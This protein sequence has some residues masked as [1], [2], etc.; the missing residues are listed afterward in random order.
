MPQCCFAP[1]SLHRLISSCPSLLQFCGLQKGEKDLPAQAW[2]RMACLGPL[3][4]VDRVPPTVTV[5]GVVFAGS[6]DT[7]LA[8]EFLPVPCHPAL[9]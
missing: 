6:S 5:G 9:S 7:Y 8:T 3:V 2:E 4:R 1:W